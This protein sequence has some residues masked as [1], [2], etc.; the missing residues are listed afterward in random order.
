MHQ[1]PA[2]SPTPKRWMELG[3]VVENQRSA[4][5]HWYLSV[6]CSLVSLAVATAA[7]QTAQTL[8]RGLPLSC[9]LRSPLHKAKSAWPALLVHKRQ[10]QWTVLGWS[11]PICWNKKQ[12][13]AELEL[14]MKCDSAAFPYDPVSALRAPSEKQTSCH[15]RTKP[16]NSRENFL[17][18]VKLLQ[19][20]NLPSPALLLLYVVFL[21]ILSL[22]N[23]QAS[24]STGS[25]A[26]LGQG[27]DSRKSLSTGLTA[28]CYQKSNKQIIIPFL[29][30][31][32]YLQD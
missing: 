20:L 6:P 11:I 18:E 12:V 26:V 21:I 9:E 4:T 24:D 10:Q 22:H 1:V 14:L 29:H 17:S 23:F 5:L 27:A 32:K 13:C 2:T 3:K 25:D 31:L 28:G 30:T 19:R 15:L 7:N 8:P 16:G